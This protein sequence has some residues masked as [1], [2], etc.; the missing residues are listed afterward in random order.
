MKKRVWMYFGAMALLSLSSMAAAEEGNWYGQGGLYLVSVENGSEDFTLGLAGINA[1]YEFSTGI[2]IE[3]VLAHGTMDE[4]M[5]VFDQPISARAGTSFGLAA[6]Y[7]Y[8][9][10]ENTRVYAKVRYTSLELEVKALGVVVTERQLEP[11][12]S[13]GLVF[14]SKDREPSPF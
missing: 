13:L 12:W 14:W 8:D 10:F 2:A 11:G 4:E 6:K 5:T 3:G 1:G 7:G 9:V